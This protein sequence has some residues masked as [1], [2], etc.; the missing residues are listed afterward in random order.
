MRVTGQVEKVV[1]NAYLIFF[2]SKEALRV[3][4]DF[5]LNFYKTLIW[6]GLEFNA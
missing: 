5:M 1:N 3:K 4:I 6:H 2:F